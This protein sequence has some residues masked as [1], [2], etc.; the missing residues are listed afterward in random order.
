M[1]GE[2]NAYQRNEEIVFSENDGTIYALNPE[3][4]HCFS[5]TGP[6]AR[7]WVLI[8]DKMTVDDLVGALMN[9]FTID[10]VAC[11]QEVS[12]YLASLVDEGLVQ[13]FPAA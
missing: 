3:I 2:T 6:S 4:G 5:F 1:S 11:R 13:T 9:E 7:I 8:G 12:T 10:E